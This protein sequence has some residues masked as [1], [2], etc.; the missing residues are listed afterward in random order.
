MYVMLLLPRLLLARETL[1]FNPFAKKTIS[2]LQMDEPT[3]T[4][5]HSVRSLWV[6]YFTHKYSFDT[7]GM[8]EDFSDH[9]M[10]FYLSYVSTKHFV[11]EEGQRVSH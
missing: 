7:Q 2:S 3:Y 1:H 6:L 5:L 9:K 8:G 10:I 11:S 4:S